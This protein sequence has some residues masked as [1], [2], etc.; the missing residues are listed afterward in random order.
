MLSLS[1]LPVELLRAVCSQLCIGKYNKGGHF[2]ISRLSRTCSRLRDIIQPLVFTAFAPESDTS[3]W[4][5]ILP[6]I[7]TLSLRPDLAQHLKYIDLAD[8]DCGDPLS[9]HDIYLLNSITT[10]LNLQ[11]SDPVIFSNL[12]PFPIIELLLLH[13]PNLIHL[14][15]TL[16]DDW[17]PLFLPAIYA[18]STPT[19]LPHLTTLTLSHHCI[20]HYRWDLGL[21]NFLAIIHAAAPNLRHLSTDNPGGEITTKFGQS[22]AVCRPRELAL[23]LPNLTHLEFDR[24]CYLLPDVLRGIVAAAPNL[25]VF[26]LSTG[27]AW[28]GVWD[29]NGNGDDRDCTVAD[30]WEVVWLRRG[31]LKE[32]RVD[33]ICDSGEWEGE[34]GDMGMRAKLEGCS[35]SLKEFKQLEVLKVGGY[36][37]EVLEKE[38]KRSNGENGVDRD[39]FVGSLLPSS[40]REVT[41]WEPEGSWMM[42]WRR[43]AEVVALLKV[44]RY[45]NLL[46]V[47]VAPVP[48]NEMPR[49]W[50]AKHE[51]LRASGELENQFQTAGVRFEIQE[52]RGNEPAGPFEMGNPFQF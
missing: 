22:T 38:G 15:L 27:S 46:S 40:I 44:E 16:S 2:D 47:V 12:N 5:Q 30:V 43:L 18:N 37:L 11:P 36:A 19:I 31:T 25:E 4:C 3:I 28:E 42:A 7:Y 52:G 45:P 17:S 8:I 41:F 33:V 13:T 14:Q 20:C 9:Q 49:E 39:G 51:W 1:N 21:S 50:K 24:V 35:G 26:S 29:R 10:K 6:L 32:L 48:D 23:E 34:G